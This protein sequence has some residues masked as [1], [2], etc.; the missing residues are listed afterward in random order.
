MQEAVPKINE[1][2]ENCLND[3]RTPS[4]TRIKRGC[5][6]SLIQPVLK[7]KN[8]LLLSVPLTPL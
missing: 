2:P 5:I 6:I 3:S 1:R 7:Q 4:D 8:D